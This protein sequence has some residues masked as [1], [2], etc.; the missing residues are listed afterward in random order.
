MHDGAWRPYAPD[1]SFGV[2]VAA[3]QELLDRIV[4]QLDRTQPPPPRPANKA[5]VVSWQR[6]AAGVRLPVGLLAAAVGLDHPVTTAVALEAAVDA[7]GR[8]AD[9]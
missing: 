8:G 1:Q 3:D 6:P 2:R 9:R 7:R 5:P 4:A